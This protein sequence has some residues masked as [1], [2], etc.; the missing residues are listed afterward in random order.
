M[1][2][3]LG[4]IVVFRGINS[5]IGSN[6]DSETNKFIDKYDSNYR[7]MNAKIRDYHCKMCFKEE[8]GTTIE[9]VLP[10]IF[11]IKLYIQMI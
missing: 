4:S 8:N 10:V 5:I 2:S 1:T 7:N 11:P 9:H 3:Y 6:H